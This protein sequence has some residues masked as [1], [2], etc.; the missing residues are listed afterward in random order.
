M[1]SLHRARKHEKANPLTFVPLGDLLLA[2]YAGLHPTIMQA[3]VVPTRTITCR[4]RQTE[5]CH[6][7]QNMMPENL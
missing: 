5:Q 6:Q 4:D 7:F 1:S 2:W 3:L